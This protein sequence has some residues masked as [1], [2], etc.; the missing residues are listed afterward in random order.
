MNT[1]HHILKKIVLNSL[2]QP[3]SKKCFPLFVSKNQNC[4]IKFYIYLI[5]AFTL[6]RKQVGFDKH[7][8]YRINFLNYDNGKA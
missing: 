6:L 8:A 4:E 2:L 1:D 7:S 5:K 3:C